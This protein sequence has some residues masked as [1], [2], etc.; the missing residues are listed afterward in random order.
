VLTDDWA[1]QW[2]RV[3]FDPCR[4]DTLNGLPKYLSQ[5]TAS[6]TPTSVP[7]LMQIR[8]WVKYTVVTVH[9]KIYLYVGCSDFTVILSNL[10]TLYDLHVVQHDVDHIVLCEVNW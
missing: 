4:I 2:E 7:N 10:W 3:N 8:P 9:Q 1:C 6:V 5:V